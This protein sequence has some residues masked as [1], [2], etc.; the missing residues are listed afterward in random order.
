MSC[1]TI[2]VSDIKN[3]KSRTYSLP[4]NLHIHQLC[5]IEEHSASFIIWS[6]IVVISTDSKSLKMQSIPDMFSLTGMDEG[7]R[8]VTHQC[9][10]LSHVN[11]GTCHTSMLVPVIRQCWYMV[12]RQCWY[13]VTL[14]CWYMSHVN[15]GTCH[16]SMLVHVKRQCW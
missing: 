10:Y 1:N 12:T 6:A 11:V 15:V 16:T 2:H 14:Q 13:M 4:I 8:S 9:W 7:H 3:V 5:L